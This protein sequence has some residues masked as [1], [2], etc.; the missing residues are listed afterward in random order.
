MMTTAV[1]IPVGSI[2]VFMQHGDRI[3]ESLGTKGPFEPQTLSKWAELCA[4][5]SVVVDVGAY[6]GLFSVGARL[7]GA[8]VIAFEPMRFNRE[9]FKANARLNHVSDQVRA[10]AVSDR[11]G[12]CTLTYNPIP[13]TAGASLIRKTGN[14]LEVKAVTIDSLQLQTV[15]AIKIDVERAEPL[16][17][18]GAIDTLKRCRPQLLVEI[19]DEERKQGVFRVLQGL[20][21][22]ASE[23]DNR[24]WW[25]RPC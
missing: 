5:G 8:E 17:L 6:T 20:Y 9:R 24:N 10:E 14:K 3:V 21:E 11:V 12:Q 18:A 16:V 23:L 25:F 4:P 15:A 2:S 1:A 7:L 19:L 13:F 22:P